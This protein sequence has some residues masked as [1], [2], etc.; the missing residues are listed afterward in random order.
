MPVLSVLV[1][2]PTNDYKSDKYEFIL[3]GSVMD[4][5]VFILRTT[6]LIHVA[7]LILSGGFDS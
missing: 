7:I 2:R 4:R 3:V 1:I 5:F 6:L